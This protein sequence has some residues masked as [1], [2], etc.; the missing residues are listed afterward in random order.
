MGVWDL[1]EKNGKTVKNMTLPR[2][3]DKQGGEYP[4]VSIAKHF[5]KVISF[6]TM[7]LLAF[8]HLD[9]VGPVLFEWCKADNV[10]ALEKVCTMDG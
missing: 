9:L 2:F 7:E 5:C 10:K 3:Q 8:K 1:V 4:L 6:D